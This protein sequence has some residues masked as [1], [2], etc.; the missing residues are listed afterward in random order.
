MTA[1]TA[2]VLTLAGT[3]PTAA[4]DSGLAAHCDAPEVEAFAARDACIATAQAV[5]S[6]QPLLGILIAGGNPTVGSA[7][8]SG[9]R[10]GL[11]PRVSAGVR[12]NVVPVRLPDILA[13][14]IP[15][16]AG[17]LA[18]RLGIPAPAVVGDLAIGITDGFAAA[19]GLGGIGGISVL[20]S[21][22]YLPFQLFDADGFDEADLAYGLGARL[23]LLEESFFVPG[24]SLSV[25]RRALPDLAFGDICP[26]GIE[27]VA[28]PGGDPDHETGACAGEGDAGEFSFDLTDWSGRLV[29]SKHFLGFGATA[30]A[31][32]D[33]YESDLGFGFRAPAAEPQTQ[34]TPVFRVTD[35]SLAATRWTLFGNLSFSFVAATLAA[36]AGWQQGEPPIS[37]FRELGGNFDPGSGAWYASLGARLSL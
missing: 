28:V 13:E 10:L 30:G 14:Q 31:G 25:M 1:L 32:Y 16:E 27:P 20:A 37:S 29:A 8:E 35:Q 3:A 22:S 2:L 21:V 19:P 36:E 15:G 33:R 26:G 34:L 6:A 23:H 12:L 5:I 4:Q 18:R 9:F 17:D 24:I 7:G 11:L